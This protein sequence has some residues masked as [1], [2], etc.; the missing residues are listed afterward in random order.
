MIRG[1]GVDLEFTIIQRYIIEINICIYKNT[2]IGKSEIKL[3]LIKL[4]NYLFQ[5]IL[6][7]G[8]LA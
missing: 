8:Q 4:R 3:Y 1:G 5:L 2:I 6:K 7:T